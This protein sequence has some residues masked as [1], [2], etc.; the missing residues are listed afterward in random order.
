MKGYISLLLNTLD[1]FE[2]GL[3][4]LLSTLN[5]ARYDQSINTREDDGSDLIY[6]TFT[7]CDNGF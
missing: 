2:E 1:Y 4:Q 6:K 5:A 7:R 3:L